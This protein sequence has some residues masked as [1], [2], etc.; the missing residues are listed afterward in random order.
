[1]VS[2]GLI[3]QPELI[4]LEAYILG[5]PFINLEKE[6][7]PSEVL[8]IIPEPIAKKHNTVALKKQGKELEGKPA[9]Y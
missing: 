5:I 2:D 7:V 6:I 1:L 8:K 9:E 3:T 4:K